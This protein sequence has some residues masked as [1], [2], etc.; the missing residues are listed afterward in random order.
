MCRSKMAYYSITS[1]ARPS[2]G[3]ADHK[4]PLRCRP[5]KKR[6]E[7]LIASFDYLVGAADKRWWDSDVERL[8]SFEVDNQF[9]F[10]CLLD[11]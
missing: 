3:V 7:F 11:R 9:N 5:G 1:S 2:S 10:G 4:P 8:S 6:S